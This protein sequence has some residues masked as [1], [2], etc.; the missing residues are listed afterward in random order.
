MTQVQLEI[1]VD[2]GGGEAGEDV[3]QIAQD[4]P[5]THGAK[6][7]LIVNNMVR[8]EQ[9]WKSDGGDCSNLEVDSKVRFVTM[10]PIQSPVWFD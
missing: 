10:E 1:R 8:M 7:M 4:W 9:R 3:A 5:W 6:V 2:G